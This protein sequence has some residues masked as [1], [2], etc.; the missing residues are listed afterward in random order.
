MATPE[1]AVDTK[2]AVD[3]KPFDPSRIH[4][5]F[6]S[7]GSTQFAKFSYDG[8]PVTLGGN[9]ATISNASDLLLFQQHVQHAL[10]D[11]FKGTKSLSPTPPLPPLPDEEAITNPANDR[12]SLK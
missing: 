7:R 1:G 3:A 11:V 2:A 4:L 10:D 5:N 9:N 12:S 6:Q 8:K